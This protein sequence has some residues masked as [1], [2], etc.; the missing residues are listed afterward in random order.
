MYLGG[1]VGVG[2]GGGFCRVFGEG[3]R[4]VRLMGWALSVFKETHYFAPVGSASLQTKS[5]LGKICSILSDSLSG[6]HVILTLILA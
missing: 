2:W 1:G 5:N 4:G 6:C 3:E